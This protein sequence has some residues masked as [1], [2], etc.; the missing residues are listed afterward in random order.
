MNK[1]VI[2]SLDCILHFY[3]SYYIGLHITT[4]NLMREAQFQKR[5]KD[6]K[7]ANAMLKEKLSCKVCREKDVD[8][9]IKMCNHCVCFQCGTICKDNGMGCP[10]CREQIYGLEKIHPG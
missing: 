9:V 6:Q 2:I 7:D 5:M 10:V 1:N 3:I 4:E 8:A